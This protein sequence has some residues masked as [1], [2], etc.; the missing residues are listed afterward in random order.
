MTLQVGE[1]KVVTF[2]DDV[3]VGGFAQAE[4]IR[5]TREAEDERPLSGLEIIGVRVRLNE[6][7]V[8]GQESVDIAG[9]NAEQNPV[10][11]VGKILLVSL[12]VEVEHAE[13]GGDHDLLGGDDRPNRVRGDQGEILDLV[14][15]ELVA[16]GHRSPKLRLSRYDFEK[17]RKVLFLEFKYLHFARPF[18]GLAEVLPGPQGPERKNPPCFKEIKKP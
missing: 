15:D 13:R 9:M 14:E 2:F 1:E 12:F 16:F 7:F 3:S 4:F 5:P 17:R 18:C 11:D 6:Q 10:G 8:Q